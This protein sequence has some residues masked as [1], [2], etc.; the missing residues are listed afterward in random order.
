M[1]V[2][3]QARKSTLVTAPKEPI[4]DITPALEALDSPRNPEFGFAG[5]HPNEVFPIGIQKPDSYDVPAD[6]LKESANF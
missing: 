3:E 4:D 5:I 1:L 6:I 2:K